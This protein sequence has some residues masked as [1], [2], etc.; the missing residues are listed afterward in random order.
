MMLKWL[1][2]FYSDKKHF[3]Y[4]PYTHYKKYGIFYKLAILIN[5]NYKLVDIRR[6]NY[7]VWGDIVVIGLRYY[8]K[9]VKRRT[10]GYAKDHLNNNPSEKCLYCLDTMTY[11][12]ITAEHIVPI[13]KGGNNCKVNLTVCCSDCNLDRGD[14]DFKSY[15]KRVRGKKPGF[16]K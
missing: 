14:T 5:P 1:K 2:L 8:G 4:L 9:N 15:Y 10:N 7:R 13:S 3:V 11:E 12:N 6:S 16:L